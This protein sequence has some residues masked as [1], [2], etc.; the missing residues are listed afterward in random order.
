MRLYYL[1]VIRPVITYGCGAW[2]VKPLESQGAKL[3]VKNKELKR[4]QSLQ[5][6][7]LWLVSGC[8]KNTARI[9]VEKDLFIQDILVVLHSVALY[10]ILTACM[11]YYFKRKNREADEKG[12]IL[13]GIRGFRYAP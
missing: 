12:T 5:G 6:D 4:L 13:E 8:H 1:T 7:F 2:L 10:I 9:F 11:S 3:V